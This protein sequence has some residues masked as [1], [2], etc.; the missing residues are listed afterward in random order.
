[1][2]FAIASSLDY[3]AF[4]PST[5]I[6][7]IEAMR[8]G[9]AIHSEAFSINPDIAHE[10]HV[11]ETGNRYRRLLLGPGSY[12]ITY[13]AEV[14]TMPSHESPGDVPEVPVSQLPLAVLPYLFASRYCPSD[15]L[16]RFAIRQF[17]QLPQGHERVTA[18]CNWIYE[19]VDY[20]RGSSDTGTTA[21][22]TFAQRAG[23]CRDF[24]HLAISFCRALGIPARFV[25]A[26]GWQLDP[27]DFHAVFEAWLGNRWYVFD[28]T[29]LSP[30]DGLVRIGVGRDA[31]DTAFSTFF[32]AI[33]PGP[34]S[35]S[36]TP[37]GPADETR[38]WT[39][40]AVS[41]SG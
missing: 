27:P 17:G 25:S 23:V 37:A 31:A 41:L 7:N 24:A 10:D 9:Q 33:T 5:L 36:I 32:G 26:Y 16:A 20:L 1:M 8:E 38:P 11:A 15:Q 6:L 40:D 12:R 39:T 22:E 29:R 13:T 14:E 35:V 2:R 21:A 19:H 18:I 30:V 3:Q 34:L 4:G 28:A